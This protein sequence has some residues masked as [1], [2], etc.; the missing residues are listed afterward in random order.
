MRGLE[1]RQSIRLNYFQLKL[2]QLC[3]SDTTFY[4]TF[5]QKYDTIFLC[6]LLSSLRSVATK[7][8]SYINTIIKIP[9]LIALP[10]AVLN[11]MSS[12][13]TPN[14]DP[15]FTKSAPSP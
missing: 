9:I 6:L 11:S 14:I 1:G 8:L 15:I 3:I 7:L 5:A 13:E 10:R 4:L 12:L 2:F